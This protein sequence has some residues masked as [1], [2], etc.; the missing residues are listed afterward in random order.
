MGIKEYDPQEAD[1][2]IL[3]A[4]GLIDETHGYGFSILKRLVE[5]NLK[6][7]LVSIVDNAEVLYQL[8]LK[9]MIFSG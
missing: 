5:F 8:P 6:P 3:E 9:T 4:D 1:I 2:I 7:A